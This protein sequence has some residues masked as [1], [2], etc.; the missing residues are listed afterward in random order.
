MKKI[1]LLLAMSVV[2]AACNNDD[3]DPTTPVNT[4][5]NFSFTQNFDGATITNA[6]FDVTTYTNANG[7]VLTLSKLV[8]LISDITFTSSTGEVFDAGDY[9][10][11][12]ARN[13]TGITF[14][15]NI[16]IPEGEY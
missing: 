11:I 12:D 14:T 3:N 13:G 6:D 16:T 2:L 5:V 8:Y 15:P 4:T 10:L 9:N 1:A 7:E